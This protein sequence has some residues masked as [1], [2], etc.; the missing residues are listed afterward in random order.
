MEIEILLSEIAISREI[1]KRMK[2]K[3]MSLFYFYTQFF[4]IG[5]SKFNFISDKEDKYFYT[6][7]NEHHYWNLFHYLYE[8]YSL[9][10]TNKNKNNDN[11]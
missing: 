11:K 4:K 9:L 7:K 8:I 5:S 2:E 1:K 3:K 6:D 10:C